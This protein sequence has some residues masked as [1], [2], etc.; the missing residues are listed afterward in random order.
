MGKW[1]LYLVR[2][3]PIILLVV[4]M[5][6][7]A[8][9]RDEDCASLLGC[10]SSTTSPEP[11]TPRSFTPAIP[12]MS[13][14]FQK[15]EKSEEGSRWHDDTPVGRGFVNISH[16][17][18]Y[19]LP[20]GIKSP[21]GP[22]SYSVAMFHQIHCL[23]MIYIEY[24]SLQKGASTAASHTTREKDHSHHHGGETYHLLHCFD[25]L[26][27]SLLC[28]GDMT[29]EPARVESDGSRIQVDGWGVAH[30]CKDLD[31]ILAWMGAH[32]GPL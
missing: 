24:R 21:A 13:V 20:P 10:W 5:S 2:G 16:P 22:D 25:I 23:K 6:V 9:L 1:L 18:I 4:L 7:V 31:T 11:I 32:H 8:T 29:I 14:V 15:T 28:A 30:Q 26:Y 19:G 17:E 12:L 27:Q 3:T